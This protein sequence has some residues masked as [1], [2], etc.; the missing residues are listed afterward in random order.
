MTLQSRLLSLSLLS[1]LS[2]SAQAGVFNTPRF[3]KPAD[4]ALGLEPEFVLTNGAGV[5]TNLRFTQGVTELNN[6]NAIVGTGSGP[7]RFRFGGNFT[8]D[9]FPDIEGQP[10]IGVAAQGIYYRVPN[11]G[12]F[13]VQA[14]PYIH[15]TFATGGGDVEPYF[16]LPFGMA[17]Q[18]GNYQAIST[19]AVGIM[20]HST[21]QIRYIGEIGIAINNQDSYISGGVVYYH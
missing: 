8:F 18:Q 6:F 21:P 11:A 16:S 19:A 10:G 2:V 3:L 12:R 1:L 5:G 13:E 15:K 17:F 20:F 9:L 14:V 7:R 4:W